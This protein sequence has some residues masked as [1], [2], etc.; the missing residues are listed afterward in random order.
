L[1]EQKRDV[2][3]DGRSTFTLFASF[4]KHT[5]SSIVALLYLLPPSFWLRRL[6]VRRLEL[7]L[8]LEVAW[9]WNSR[10]CHHTTLVDCSAP[11]SSRL[12]HFTSTVLPPP[13]STAATLLL[14]VSTTPR[15]RQTANEPHKIISPRTQYKTRELPP[16]ASGLATA[17]LN[18]Q[19]TTS[20]N[21]LLLSLQRCAHPN[22]RFETARGSY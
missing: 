15:I 7:G 21:S 8:G 10:Q 1:F 18:Q 4:R 6:V 17:L 14:Q 13:P 2:Q 22:P 3:Q 19:R 12:H 20:T 11:D 16:S 9:D 5:E